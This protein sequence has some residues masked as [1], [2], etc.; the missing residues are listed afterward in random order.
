MQFYLFVFGSY[1]FA[2]KNIT[3]VLIIKQNSDSLKAK[4]EITMIKNNGKILVSEVDFFKKL[5]V[6]DSNGEKLYKLKPNEIKE[7]SFYD[8]DN[9]KR[10]YYKDPSK[11]QLMELYYNGKIKVFKQFVPMDHYIGIYFQ[12]IQPD[13]RPYKVGLFEN[14]TKILLRITES[15]PELKKMIK[16]L[17]KDEDGIIKILTEFEK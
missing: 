5:N 8:I 2:Q 4:M 14:N 6:V 1:I 3:D 17:E 9:K 13:G 16:D 10:I 12:F 7:L 15:K 11:N